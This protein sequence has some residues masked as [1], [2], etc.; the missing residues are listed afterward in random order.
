MKTKKFKVN[1]RISS[2]AYINS[3]ETYKDLY[4]NSLNDNFKFWDEIGKRDLSWFRNFKNVYNGNFKKGDIK[5]F[6]D[7]KL[8]ASYNCIDRHIK[9]KGNKIAIIWE[10]DEPRNIKKFTYNEVLKN[11]CKIASIF[12]TY[13]VTKG[14]C[15]T[16]YMPN[17]PECAFAMLALARLG[18]PHSVVFAGFSADALRDRII[19]SKS[20]FIV[21]VDGGLRGGKKLSLKKTVDKAISSISIENGGP[22]IIH[23]CFIFQH[24]GIDIDISPKRDL[25]MNRNSNDPIANAKE[26]IPCEEMD[27]EDSLFYLYTSGSTGKPKGIVHSTAGYLL[28][29]LITHRYVF[30]Y[31]E[32][33]IYACVADCGWITGHTYI[34]YGPLANG[35]TTFMFESTPLY[36]DPS[37]YWDMIERHKIN[38]FYTSPTAI[39]TLM[40]FG[41]N[42]VKKHD[43]SSLRILGS[44]GEPINPDAWEWYYNIVGD[45]KCQIVDTWWQTETG[46]NMI[47]PLPGCTLSKP[48]SATFPFFGIEPVLIDSLSGK[49]IKWEK[50]KKSEG[51]L[52]IR[53][54]WPGIARTIFCDHERYL[55]TY[56]RPYE[57]FYFTGDGCIKDEEGY[58]WIT[59]RVDDVINV[60]GHRIGTAEIESTLLTNDNTYGAAVVGYPHET[61]GEGIFCFVIG[62]NYSSNID[63][64]KDL[65][66]TVRNKIG[67]FAT[68]DKILIVSNFPKTRSGKVMRRILRKMASGDIDN[69]GDIS[70]L[71]NPEIVSEILLLL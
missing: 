12:K 11:V 29:A 4:D 16:I 28:Y 42:L 70:T 55:D 25:W 49:E 35:G 43:L 57:G 10:G 58:L 71:A 64:I 3:M 20:K 13:G 33:D 26:Y 63:Y 47:T 46:G 5:W 31:H 8:N 38:Q 6:I 19:N 65:K 53:K 62:K 21:T 68:P 40:S 30:D 60:S 56:F 23:K 1:E 50:G 27:S 9:E 66:Y 22:E 48:G 39:R 41:D 54:P 59:G 14:E 45:K 51:I 69:L 44:V 15:V 52:C 67:P 24:T 17:I 2:K 36:P 7:G 37:R 18:A 32:N 61:K 34:I